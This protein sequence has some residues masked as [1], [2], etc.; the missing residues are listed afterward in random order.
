ML[1]KMKE[2]KTSLI[3]NCK[4]EEVIMMYSLHQVLL[5]AIE[6]EFICID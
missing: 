6:N 2:I 5:F 3:K 4:I 1:W